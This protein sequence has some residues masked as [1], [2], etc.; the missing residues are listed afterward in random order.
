MK[1]KQCVW[2]SMFC[3]CFTDH[4]LLML[5]AVT[6]KVVIILQRH[7]NMWLFCS[8]IWNT[9][10]GIVMLTHVL[11][12]V[13]NIYTFHQSLSFSCEVFLKL[14][15]FLLSLSD[16]RAE[17]EPVRRFYTARLCTRCWVKAFCF[18]ASAEI[19]KVLSFWL[20]GICSGDA[21]VS[22]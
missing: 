9:S 15:Q 4:Y 14:H 20:T 7:E 1:K 18:I 2:N 3:A 22:Y 5:L 19:W 12:A 11:F 21:P 6:I 17:R 13:H 10:W 8:F 16:A